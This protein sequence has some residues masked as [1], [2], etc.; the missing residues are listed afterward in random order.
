MTGPSA[1]AALIAA[2]VALGL[3]CALPAGAARPPACTLA[4][5]PTDPAWSLPDAFRPTTTRERLE[6]R[7]GAGSV[8]DQEIVGANGA[9]YHMLT[10]FPDDPSRRLQFA[11]GPDWR[12]SSITITDPDSRWRTGN[13]LRIGM[14][15]AQLAAC[16]GKPVTFPGFGQRGNSYLQDWNGGRF[17][18]G[19]DAAHDVIVRLAPRAGTD[20]A[21]PRTDAEIHSD[22]PAWV[23]LGDAVVVDAILLRWRTPRG[24]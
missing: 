13:G 20:A 12:V 24:N 22:D 1:R 9:Y 3:V 7:F 8:H 10:L 16:N 21:V 19:D 5:A 4:T 2:S 23:T 15:L 6:Q 17:A 11:I 18:S 14:T